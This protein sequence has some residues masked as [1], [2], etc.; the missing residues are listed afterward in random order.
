MECFIP[1]E[2]GIV[3]G[4]VVD[5]VTLDKLRSSKQDRLFVIFDECLEI[6]FYLKGK[7]LSI[8]SISIWI[9]EAI[10]LESSEQNIFTQIECH[11]GVLLR[12]EESTYARKIFRSSVVM[13]NG[14]NNKVRLVVRYGEKSV[15]KRLNG[16]SLQEEEEERDSSDDEMLTS[17]E[18]VYS[19]L[20]S[21]DSELE[22]VS[23]T[24]V[25]KADDEGIGSEDQNQKDEIFELEYPIYSLINMRLRNTALEQISSIISCLEFQTSK[26]A[27]SLISKHYTSES[28]SMHFDRVSYNLVNRKAQTEIEPVSKFT[29]PFEVYLRDSYSINYKLP[30]LQNNQIY[31]HH[32]RINLKYEL[33]IGDK[34]FPVNTIWETDIALKRPVNPN[35]IPNASSSTLAVNQSAKPFGVS[36]RLSAT[37][38]STPSLLYN[39]LKNVKFSILNNNLKV[40]MG[41]KFV[42]R[43]QIINTSPVP[44]D[45]VVYYNN[46]SP[47][48]QNSSNMTLDRQIQ[49]YKKYKKIT[50]GIILL[51]NDYKI[52]IIDPHETYFVD[53]S[54]IAI[55]PGYYQSLAGLKLLDL[56]TNELIDIGTG[57]SIL[58]QE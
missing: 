55:M 20:P 44:L 47:V 26:A 2:R 30:L 51:S 17:F 53:L 38:V 4:G 10:V 14:Y 6:Y 39:K 11:E 29:M 40:D 32:V 41:K 50:E 21:D 5:E 49:L 8:N 22:K 58:V 9:N 16:I 18:P 33:V 13:T 23:S 25:T 31:P 48:I 35:L 43:L 7:N 1:T 56:K 45:L 54:F 24:T 19:L 27:E 15:I 57:A 12:L 3:T 28:F 46:Q 42:L 52:P 36:P 34:R 37:A